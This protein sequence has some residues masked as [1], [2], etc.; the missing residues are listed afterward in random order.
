MGPQTTRLDL[1]GPVA[2]IT[3]WLTVLVSVV[4]SLE[5]DWPRKASLPLAKGKRA[6]STATGEMKKKVA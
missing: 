2:F 5:V 6:V 3:S 4:S 1:A